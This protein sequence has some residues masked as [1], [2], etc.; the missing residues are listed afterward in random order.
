M[1]TEGGFMTYEDGTMT[2]K[3]G[4]MNWEG[5]TLISEGLTTFL[6][7]HYCIPRVNYD[8]GVIIWL[9]EMICRRI[10]RLQIL[11]K[12]S[13]PSPSAAKGAVFQSAGRF[14]PR[15]TPPPPYPP[16]T[17]TTVC[18]SLG[19]RRCIWFDGDALQRPR[20][21]LGRRKWLVFFCLFFF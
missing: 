3:G 14:G 17:C 11:S 10:S 21:Y 2:L 5:G 9:L 6:E 18:S 19:L 15:S 16:L 12:H 13:P 7:R 20:S 8:Q 4:S 1:T